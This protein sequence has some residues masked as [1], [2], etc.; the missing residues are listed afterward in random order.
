MGLERDLC[1]STS[2]QPLCSS[3]FCF[4]KFL[5]QWFIFF[6][7]RIWGRKIT[8]R[9]KAPSTRIIRFCWET[10]GFFNLF[11]LPFTRIRWK[12]SPKAHHFKNSLQSEDFWKRWPLAYVWRDENGGFRIRWCNTSFTT[13]KTHALWG[14]LSY[15]RCL[16]FSCGRP[17]TIRIRYLWRRI[18]WKTEEKIFVFKNIQIRVE[19]A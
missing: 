4:A 17:K 15:F 5:F 7:V 19:G 14:I 8:F 11:G 2:A 6:S 13:S 9:K 3:S 18:F 1:H 16:S 12:R 10:E